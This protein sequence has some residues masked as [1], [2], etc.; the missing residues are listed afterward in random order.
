MSSIQ[1]YDFMTPVEDII[2]PEEAIA[3]ATQVDEAQM[4]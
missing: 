2:I 4:D 1:S 3:E